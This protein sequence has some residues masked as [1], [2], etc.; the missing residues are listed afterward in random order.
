MGV[1][2]AFLSAAACLPGAGTG[3]VAHTATPA[4]TAYL[5]GVAITR[6]GCADRIVF[7]FERGTPS[8]TVRFSSAAAAQI[9]DASGRYIP[10]AGHEFLVVRLRDT[11][12][13]RSKGGKLTMTYTGPRRLAP[14]PARHIREVVKTGDFEAVVTWAIGLDAKRPFRVRSSGSTL[15]VTIG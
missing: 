4:A 13:A 6:P 14:G 15:V 3:A 2:A 12:T 1:L 7:R 8:Y 11:L 9:E 10:V 5:T